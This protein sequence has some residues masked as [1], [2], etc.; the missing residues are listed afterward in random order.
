[1]VGVE[2]SDV[3]MG[4]GEGVVE[5]EGVAV[6]EGV[7]RRRREGTVRDSDVEMSV[8]S[9]DLRRRFWEGTVPDSDVEMSVYSADL[10]RR[11][12]EGTVPDSMASESDLDWE[13]AEE[14]GAGE[15]QAAFNLDPESQ[16]RTETDGLSPETSP[17]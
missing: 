15:G 12:R 10:R 14:G 11:F 6:V 8:Y 16:P 4:V 3:E 2:R 9:A 17:P 7:A 5:E 13:A 1:M